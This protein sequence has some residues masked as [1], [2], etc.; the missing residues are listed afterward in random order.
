MLQLTVLDVIAGREAAF[1]A[2][3]SQAQ[4]L[5]ANA[6][7]YVSH[8]LRRSVELPSRYL[9]L[10][11]WRHL[12]DHTITFRQ[13]PDHVTWKALLDPFY[14]KKPESMHYAALNADNDLPR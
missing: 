1:E 3:F 5:L 6:E 9:L 12:E 4:T 14:A 10:V 2:T 11:Q 13:A 7:G 8:S